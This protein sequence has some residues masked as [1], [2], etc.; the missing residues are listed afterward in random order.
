MTIE[1]MFEHL[2]PDNKKLVI[3]A[4]EELIQQQGEK[5]VQK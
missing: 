5:E 3:A 2:T 4:I 1:K